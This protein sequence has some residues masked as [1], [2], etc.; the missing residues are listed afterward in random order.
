MHDNRILM[1][2]VGKLEPGEFE[3]W[4]QSA[5]WPIY[6]IRVQERERTSTGAPGPVSKVLLILGDEDG[7]RIVTSPGTARR[8]RRV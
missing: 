1:R 3:T 5:W 4:H 7:P 8:V 6:S 2:A